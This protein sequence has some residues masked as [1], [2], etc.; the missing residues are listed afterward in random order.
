MKTY[1][2]DLFQ[3]PSVIVNVS[4]DDEKQFEINGWVNKKQHM[5]A[6][7]VVSNEVTKFFENKNDDSFNIILFKWL[8]K[9]NAISNY[10]SKLQNKFLELFTQQI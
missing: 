8:A 2:I 3:K 10:N 7:I 4:E 5:S 9:H 6:S 1:K